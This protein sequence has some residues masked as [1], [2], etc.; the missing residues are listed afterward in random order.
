MKRKQVYKVTFA[1][2]SFAEVEVEAKSREEAREKAWKEWE[3]KGN[4]F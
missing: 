2:E 1:F 3:T 4:K